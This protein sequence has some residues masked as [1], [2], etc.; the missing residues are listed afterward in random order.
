[1]P[2][3][4]RKGKEKAKNQDSADIDPFVDVDDDVTVPIERF[5]TVKTI[6]GQPNPTR[7]KLKKYWEDEAE[8]RRMRIEKVEEAEGKCSIAHM[9]AYEAA[10]EV[11]RCDMHPA[12]HF[13][14]HRKPSC[15]H[16]ES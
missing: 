10:I 3:W 11:R 15:F 7:E 4:S 14:R 6:D 1:M 8:R 12:S 13:S 5:R 2:F 16:L 9:A